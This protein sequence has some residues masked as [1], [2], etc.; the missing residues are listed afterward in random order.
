[1]TTSAL[2]N[3]PTSTTG[4]SPFVTISNTAPTSTMEDINI[5][6]TSSGTSTLLA[7]MIKGTASTLL[8][9]SSLTTSATTINDPTSTTESL[10][11]DI[12]HFTTRDQT[13]TGVVPDK[14]N[15]V[16]IVIVDSKL[17]ITLSATSLVI[18]VHCFSSG[19][20][21]TYTCALCT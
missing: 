10:G 5:S 7:T 11:K 12:D 9:G 2:T 19:C 1:M 14:E 13:E 21:C 18:N 8:E 17:A 16:S 4:V 3:E 6:T 15:D 20:V